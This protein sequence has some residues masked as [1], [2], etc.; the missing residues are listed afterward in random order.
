LGFLKIIEVTP[1][2][3]KENILVKKK[4]RIIENQSYFLNKA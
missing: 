4:E 1:L 3:D 2:N